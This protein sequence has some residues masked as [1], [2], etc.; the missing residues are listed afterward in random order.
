M[1]KTV[2]LI[3][4]REMLLAV[5]STLLGKKKR[6]GDVSVEC[7]VEWSHARLPLHSFLAT[8]FHI[9][10]LVGQVISA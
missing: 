2:K 6:P 3:V 7:H 5:S 8:S 10:V 4:I 1:V 9:K